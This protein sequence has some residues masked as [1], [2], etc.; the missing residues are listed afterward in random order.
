[1]QLHRQIENTITTAIGNTFTP[2]IGNTIT[3]AMVQIGII[4]LKIF[5][6]GLSIVNVRTYYSIQLG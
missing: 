4:F 5:T 3:T 6:Q 2:A 1:M